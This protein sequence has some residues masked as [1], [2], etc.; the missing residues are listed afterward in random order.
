[1][2]TQIFDCVKQLEYLDIWFYSQTD[3]LCTSIVKFKNLRHLDLVVDWNDRSLH[4]EK[5]A[6]L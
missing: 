1:M 2:L 4:I 5:L 6:A 3:R